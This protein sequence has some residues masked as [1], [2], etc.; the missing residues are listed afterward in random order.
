MATGWLRGV[1]KEVSSGD[2]VVVVSSGCSSHEQIPP[3]CQALRQE[4]RLILSGIMAPRLGRRDGSTN[5]EPGAWSSRENLRR[6]LVGQGVVFRVDDVIKGKNLEFGTVF[7]SQNNNAALLQV[8]AGLARAKD[9]KSDLAHQLKQAEEAARNKGL[10]IWT[11]GENSSG[12]ERKQNPR[13]KVLGVGDGDGCVTAQ[14]LVDRSKLRNRMRYGCVVESVGNPHV[15]RVLV[16]PTDSEKQKREFVQ[17]TVFLCGVACPLVQRRQQEGQETQGTE[18]FGVRSKVFVENLVLSRDCEVCFEELDKFGN[19]YASVYTPQ[20]ESVAELLLREGLAKVLD[21]S[22]RMLP[23]L[24]S[25]KQ[26]Q[27]EKAA[28]ARKANLWHDYVP[29]AG[30]SEDAGGEMKCIVTEVVSGDTVVLLSLK[31]RSERRVHLSSLRA[32]RMPTRGNNN[33]GEPWAEEA[34]EVLRQKIVGKEVTARIEYERKVP[35]GGGGQQGGG[36]Q[37]QQQQM[38]TLSFASIS[39]EERQG[40]SPKTVNVSEVLLSRGL[41]T[42]QNH[43]SGDVRAEN[44][45]EMVEAEARAVKN[46]K[47]IHGGKKPSSGGRMN[48]LSVNSSAQ[49][50]KQFLPFLQRSDRVNAIVDYVLSGHRYKLLVPKQAI[51]LTFALSDV[52]CPG[53]NEP[54]SDEAL[55]YARVHCMQRDVEIEVE[56]IDKMG[57]FTGKL[58]LLHGNNKRIDIAEQLLSQ[59]LATIHGYNV[60]SGSP[61]T[62]AQSRAKDA[63]INLWKDYQEPDAQAE[64]EAESSSGNGAQHQKEE[65]KIR[66]VCVVSGG[67]FYAQKADDE[68]DALLKEVAGLGLSES[69]AGDSARYQNGE[70]VLCK[71]KGDGQVYRARVER[72]DDKAK[73]YEVFYVDFGNRDVVTAKELSPIE[74]NLQL[75]SSKPL[76]FACQLAGVKVPKLEEDFGYEA[77]S[78]LQGLIGRG[79]V[80]D[81]TVESRSSEVVQGR[82][83]ETVAR[84]ALT[85]PETHEAIALELV[86]QGLA[87]VERNKRSVL[88]QSDAYAALKEEE[89]KAR[90][91]HLNIW[92]YGD[93]GS[94][95]EEDGRPSAWGSR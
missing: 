88:H 13:R 36:D 53:R 7:D 23:S 92:E 72:Y 94:D 63:R 29:S 70:V 65:V 93:I 25:S 50:S 80:L 64:A 31:D 26:R 78:E 30:V 32:P 49:K 8:S 12:K 47:G 86:K 46:K 61:L 24:A 84:V 28:K 43:R 18:A 76:A 89:E 42:C 67:L 66:C 48:D 68:A 40:G 69:S 95:D 4:K 79:Q 85:D 71:Y 33:Q 73:T 1:V 74:G 5:E 58:R 54:Y 91:D 9:G 81:A 6:A 19:V 52:R 35:L 51:A 39:Y 27:A 15:L 75:K 60:S 16:K 21:W 34:K 59:G 55:K 3:N 83:P 11:F 82:R 41:A 87:R 14:S 77:A 37:Q 57:T 90:K 2:S 10:G 56:S 22:G 45:E 17:A 20:G 62:L 44:F 38:R